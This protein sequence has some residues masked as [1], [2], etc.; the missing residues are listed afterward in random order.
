VAT[1]ST[2]ISDHAS[3]SSALLLMTEADSKPAS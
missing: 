1:S 3:F 2:K